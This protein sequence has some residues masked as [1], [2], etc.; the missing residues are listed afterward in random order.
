MKNYVLVLFA[1]LLIA[2][3]SRIM[4]QDFE[5]TKRTII[6]V[7]LRAEV[8]TDMPDGNTIYNYIVLYDN[9][10][11]LA[12][13]DQN[14]I[15]NFT[16]PAFANGIFNKKI[17]WKGVKS[18]FDPNYRPKVTNISKKSDENQ[19]F[20]YLKNRKEING[21]IEYKVKKKVPDQIT[22]SYTITIEINGETYTID[23]IIRYHQ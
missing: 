19:N 6:Y 10:G 2:G 12:I 9:H 13:K 15:T 5:Q 23:P 18:D 3:S 22:E 7:K 4:A 11:N 16:S 21:A 8:P 14:L 17:K 1:F 20:T